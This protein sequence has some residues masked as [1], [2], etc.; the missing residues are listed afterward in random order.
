MHNI[1]P[2]TFYVDP[3]NHFNFDP[4]FVADLI[5][6][7]QIMQ[8]YMLRYRGGRKKKKHPGVEPPKCLISY[9]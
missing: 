3:I 9:L 1:N 8:K 4:T 2:S 7:I 6:P 5:L